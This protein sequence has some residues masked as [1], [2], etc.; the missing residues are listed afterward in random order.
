MELR[1]LRYFIAVA[2]EGGLKTAAEKRLHTS[3]PSLSRQIRDLEVEV[4]AELLRRG[5]RGVELTPAGRTFLDHARLAVAQAEA[6]MES[7]R[8]I[9]RPAKPVFSVG[10]LV[11]HEAD[12][13]PAAAQIL[14]TE[15]PD[16]EVRVFSGFSIDL[17]DD[18][19]SGKLD[20]AFLRREPRAD[21]EYQLVAREPLVTIL[22]I[23][24]RLARFDAI[25]PREFAY[26]TFIGISRVPRVLRA[27]VNGYLAESGVEITPHLEID[28][29]AMAISLVEATRGVA[30]LPISIES[31][32]PPSLTSRPLKGKQ[33]IVDL[34]MGYSRAAKSPLFEKFLAKFDQLTERIRQLARRP[35]SPQG[36]ELGAPWQ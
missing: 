18:L 10:I 22:P 15:F 6:A 30:M 20:V 34:V 7:A 25:D 9:A 24:H 4:G 33:P 27:A 31:F 28:N 5:P 35:V 3:Q 23:D 21:L 13:L 1:H 16:I 26:E 2:E 29:F 36:D 8:R 14:Q 32:L 12:C 19:A 17:A 11:G